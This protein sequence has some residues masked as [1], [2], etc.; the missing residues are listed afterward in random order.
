MDIDSPMPKNYARHY[1]VSSL[2]QEALAPLL[3]AAVG[4]GLLTL[5]RVELNGDFSV[6]TVVYAMVGGD[7][8][9]AQA[10]LEQ[11]AGAWRRQLARRLNMRKTP[12][13]VF[14]YDDEGLAADGMRRLL[15]R[16]DEGEKTA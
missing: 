9:R 4:D 13:L 6:A 3:A 8:Q 15:E 12:R 10:V 7:A 1:R 16:I 14:A 11:A 5:R 2:L